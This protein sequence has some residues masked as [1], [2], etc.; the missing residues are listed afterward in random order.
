[1]FDFSIVLGYWIYKESH[2]R[3][4]A[5]GGVLILLNFEQYDCISETIS[6][7]DGNICKLSGAK[8]RREEFFT[9]FKSL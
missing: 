8:G 1:M 5:I 4:L 2:D 6:S 9:Y 7:E 3:T